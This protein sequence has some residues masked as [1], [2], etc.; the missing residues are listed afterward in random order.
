MG[1]FMVD[2]LNPFYWVSQ[3]PTSNSEKLKITWTSLWA[4]SKDW[5][6]KIMIFIIFFP[7]QT[8]LMMSF[9]QGRYD[10]SFW[11]SPSSS[12]FIVFRR[13]TLSYSLLSIIISLKWPIES[14]ICSQCLHHISN[15][16]RCVNF[17][18]INRHPKMTNEIALN[19]WGG[20]VAKKVALNEWHLKNLVV[21]P[22]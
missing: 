12:A 19:K 10:R 8:R 4:S 13:Y 17:V 11:D 2:A 16:N 5:A 3:W 1:F 20:E 9:L 7:G 18:Q 22:S 14:Y 6:P 21:C 15:K